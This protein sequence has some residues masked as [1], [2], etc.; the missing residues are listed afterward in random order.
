MYIYNRKQ[1]ISHCDS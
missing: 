1:N